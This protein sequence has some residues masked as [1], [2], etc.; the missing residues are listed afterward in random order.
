MQKHG[1]ETRILTVR[2]LSCL[3]K[4]VCSQIWPNYR[5]LEIVIQRAT[6]IWAKLI[7]QKF[8]IVIKNKCCNI[9]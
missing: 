7:N 9:L 4:A 5:L 1:N 3:H 2:T 6:Y 8:Y